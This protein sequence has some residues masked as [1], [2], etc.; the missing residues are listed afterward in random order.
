MA[1][2]D[3]TTE[4][5]ATSGTPDKPG[6]ITHYLEVIERYDKGTEEWKNRCEKIIKIYLDQHRTNASPRRFALL[7][8]NIETLKPAIY[9]RLPI[10]VVSRRYKD[11]DEAGRKAAEVLERCIN[12][13]FDL[14][15]IDAV[16][17]LV[18]DDRLLTSRGQAWVRYEADIEGDE[19]KPEGEQ[20]AAAPT[21][22]YEKV[23]CDHV[24]WKDFGHSMNCT[25]PEVTI[26]WRRVYMDRDKVTKRWG[27]TKADKLEYEVRQEHQLGTDQNKD[28]LEP[29]AMVYEIWDKD[30]RQTIWI[31]KEEKLILE[32][33]EPPLAFRNFFPCPEP[34][35]GTKAT[36]SLVVTPDYRYYQDQAEEIDDLT[37]KISDLTSWLRLKGFYAGGPSSEGTDAIEEAL[38][39]EGNQ[40][41]VKVEFLGGVRREGRGARAHRMD[42]ARRD[43]QGAQRRRGG[44][45]AAHQRRVSVDR[46]Q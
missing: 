19:A 5:P 22:K 40:I 38:K 23:C 43:G 45:H 31:A 4:N 41:L 34:V 37:Q 28:E 27:K 44:A 1:A 33:G 26:V 24:N 32:Q 36:G 10:A 39:M 8:S 6:S 7:W 29:Q 16:L 42:A 18:R 12:T 11:K 14:Y 15:G 2:D 35:Y 20:P 30:K 46:H 3:K 21:V 17:R 13:S 9:A 25:W